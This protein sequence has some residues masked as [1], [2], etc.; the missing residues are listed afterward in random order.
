MFLG[1]LTFGGFQMEVYSFQN[2]VRLCCAI[3][4][5]LIF[6]DIVAF[7]DTLGPIFSFRKIQN[8][9]SVPLWPDAK[10]PSYQIK[11]ENI[12]SSP[13]YTKRL[14]TED[15]VDGEM[16]HNVALLLVELLGLAILL[17]ADSYA[18]VFVSSN[19]HILIS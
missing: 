10:E 7:F 1:T 6:L 19:L 16:V 11:S 17:V 5:T 3:F 15:V 12:S 2:K 14:K 4:T 13:N 8:G 9:S 18:F